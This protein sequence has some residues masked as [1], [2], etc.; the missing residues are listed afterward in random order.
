MFSLFLLSL[1]GI[2]S[3]EKERGESVLL[4]N[5]M[6]IPEVETETGISTVGIPTNKVETETGNGALK[7]ASGLCFRCHLRDYE[8]DLPRE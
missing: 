4:S 3:D 6:G 2:K 1:F 8:R 5:K 7:H